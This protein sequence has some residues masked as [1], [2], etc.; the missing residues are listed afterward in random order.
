MFFTIFQFIWQF[1]SSVRACCNAVP[2]CGTISKRTYC[3]VLIQDGT[4]SRTVHVH[5]RRTVPTQV[6]CYLL[7]ITAAAVERR[8]TTHPSTQRTFSWGNRTSLHR[9]ILLSRRTPVVGM[10]H[11]NQYQRHNQRTEE[12]PR[13]NKKTAPRTGSSTNTRAATAQSQ[14]HIDHTRTDSNADAA[15]IVRAEPENITEPT[16]DRSA[17]TSRNSEYEP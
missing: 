16:A 3:A 4:R 8:G 10:R 9:K 12:R 5:E 1:P 6:C 17:A 2:V 11:Q 14:H 13:P 15:G 7:C